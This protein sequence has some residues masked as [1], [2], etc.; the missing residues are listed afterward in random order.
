MGRVFCLK[1]HVEVICSVLLT[2]WSAWKVVCAALPNA[3]VNID[4]ELIFIVMLQ[5]ESI[6]EILR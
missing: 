2:V 6:T 1:A 5:M 4:I 3:R